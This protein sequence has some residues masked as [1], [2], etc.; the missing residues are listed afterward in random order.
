MSSDSKLVR[1]TDWTVR[2]VAVFAFL[3]AGYT[4][5]ETSQRAKCQAQ[6][7]QLSSERTRALAPVSGVV[8]AKVDGIEAAAGKL[9]GHVRTNNKKPNT[10]SQAQ[11]LKEF[12]AYIESIEQYNVARAKQREELAAHPVPPE[13]KDLCG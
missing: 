3:V 9:W 4:S 12:D 13:P 11:I 10:Y 6:F 5:Y 7:N 2:L 1:Y 8:A